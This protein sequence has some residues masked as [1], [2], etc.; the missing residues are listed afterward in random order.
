MLINARVRTPKATIRIAVAIETIRKCLQKN[1][2]HP[3]LDFDVDVVV[4]V[5]E[6]VEVEAEEVS[7]MRI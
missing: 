7:D 6:A 5:V 4:V 2:M 3:H 1:V